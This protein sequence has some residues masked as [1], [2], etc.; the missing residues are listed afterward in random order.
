ML[1]CRLV[2]IAEDF[3]EDGQGSF[4]F[5]HSCDDTPPGEGGAETDICA[6]ES[7]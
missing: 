3:G 1:F 4:A 6:L 5:G 7:L 2:L